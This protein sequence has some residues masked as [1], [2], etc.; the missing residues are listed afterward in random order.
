[1]MDQVQLFQQPLPFTLSRMW[2]YQFIHLR[3][4]LRDTNTSS[5]FSIQKNVTLL[6]KQ[7]NTYNTRKKESLLELEF[8]MIRSIIK[9]FMSLF[10]EKYE[11][12][13]FFLSL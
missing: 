10:I 6:R 2:T 3:K 8:Q 9:S 5:Y 13:L 11:G 12:R 7:G 1:M 4:I